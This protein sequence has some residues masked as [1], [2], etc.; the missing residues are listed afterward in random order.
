MKSKLLFI[1][2]VLSSI[3]G[4]TQINLPAASP[5]AK[6][7]QTIGFTDIT[8]AYS[9]PSKRDRILFGEKGLLPYGELWRTGANAATKLTF[10]TKIKINDISLNKGNYALLTIPGIKEWRINMYTYESTNWLSY[11]TKEPITS[12][13]V[14]TQTSTEV[15][16]S[17]HIYFDNITLTS[18]ILVLHW[19][20]VK[21]N[22]PVATEIQDQALNNIAK[23]L[24]GPSSLDYFQAAVYLHD[25]QTEL[26]KALEFIEK[27]TASDPQFF[28]MHRKALILND[29]GRKEEAI[30]A[31]K[32]SLNLAKKAKNNDFIRLN[33][34]F[35]AQSSQ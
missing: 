18:G 14:T 20:T 6:V 13:T 8:I 21:I 9:R 27:A 32:T 22:I 10:S 29:L 17:F 24:S 3:Y 7:Q 34:L 26:T 5:N 15:K 35:I 19:D 4:H 30:I 11:I 28:Q 23:K 33:E 31:A 1:L 2:L 12:F 25:T 16:E